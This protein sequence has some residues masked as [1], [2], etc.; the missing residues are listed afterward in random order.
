MLSLVLGHWNDGLL[1]F[2]CTLDWDYEFLCLGK[3]SCP[4]LGYRCIDPNELCC[5]PETNFGCKVNRTTTFLLFCSFRLWLFL[6]LASC[7]VSYEFVCSALSFV[8]LLCL[9]RFSLFPWLGCFQGLFQFLLSKWTN[10]DPFFKN[11]LD[12]SD[13]HFSLVGT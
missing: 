12:G 11:K 4:E 13:Q 5:D 1:G 3:I 6:W 10:P 7:F 8:Y 2:L 9:T